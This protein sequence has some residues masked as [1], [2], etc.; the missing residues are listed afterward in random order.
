MWLTERKKE[1]PVTNK[2]Q[3]H[4]MRVCKKRSYICYSGATLWYSLD[5]NVKSA[6]NLMSLKSNI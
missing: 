2:T 1:D 3:V 5:E 6:I 4:C